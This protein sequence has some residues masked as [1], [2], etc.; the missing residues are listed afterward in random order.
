MDSEPRVS[1]GGSFFRAFHSLGHLVGFFDQARWLGGYVD[2]PLPG[3]RYFRALQ[4]PF[5]APAMNVALVASAATFRPDLVLVLKGSHWLPETIDA[6]R[7]IAGAVV[8]F[9]PDDLANPL[10]TTERMLAALPLWSVVFTPRAFAMPEIRAHGARRVEHLPFGYDP[11][12]HFPDRSAGAL[13]R[14][15]DAAATFVGTAAP[16]RV[17]S[18]E[19]L[20][21]RVPC[22]VFGY[23]WERLPA[24]SPLAPVRREPVF[25]A[26]AREVFTASAL[27][28]ALLRRANRDLHQMRSFEVPACAGLLLTERS[29][30]HA[31]WFDEDV[32]ALFFDGD[33]ELAEKA[34]R[35]LRD[36]PAARR[37]AEAGHRRLLAGR[38]SYRDR[39][40]RLLEVVAE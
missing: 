25:D 33:E 37:I 4:R 32:E 11:E 13:S 35:Y 1:V 6:L 17:T 27:N 31:A 22:R 30:D 8:A 26:G 12:L 2:K 3:A 18:L 36:R 9:H 7:R 24:G 20:A 15:V 38:H 5:V 19:F 29:P 10:N 14:D 28:V 16:E 34:A 39:A 23:G 40:A 21:A